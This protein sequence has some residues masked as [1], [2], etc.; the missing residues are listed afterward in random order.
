MEMEGRIDEFHCYPPHE[1]QTG[2]RVPVKYTQGRA[3]VNIEFSENQKAEYPR[4]AM[5]LNPPN[6]QVI[7]RVQ[8][9]TWSRGEPRKENTFI[10]SISFWKTPEG[11]AVVKVNIYLPMSMYAKLIQMNGYEIT[12]QTLHEYV[13]QENVNQEVAL[14]RAAD[15]EVSLTQAPSWPTSA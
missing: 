4:E 14:V 7:E 12:L 15:F 6:P 8:L 10:G 13:E 5:P 9:T 2:E 11:R 3:W 1:G